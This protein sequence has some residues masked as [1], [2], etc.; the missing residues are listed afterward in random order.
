[1]ATRN[2]V[3]LAGKRRTT[4]YSKAFGRRSAPEEK[5]KDGR[6]CT[7]PLES[8]T[9][10]DFQDDDEINSP[11]VTLPKKNKL[12]GRKAGGRMQ[13]TSRFTECSRSRLF[14]TTLTTAISPITIRSDHAATTATDRSEI[15]EA[16]ISSEDSF[17]WIIQV[18]HEGRGHESIPKNVKALNIN[19]QKKEMVQTHI[20]FRPVQT[21]HSV[22]VVRQE[23]SS[24]SKMGP[25][26]SATKTQQVPGTRKRKRLID[27]LAAQADD[28]SG[29]EEQEQEPDWSQV[30]R[31][32]PEPQGLP[33][34]GTPAVAPSTPEPKIPKKFA[35]PGSAT[36]RTGPKITYSARRTI[37]AEG[38]SAGGL[39][40][41]DEDAW[42]KESLLPTGGSRFDMDEDED[43]PFT[44][45][46]VRSIHELRQAGANTR[47]ADEIED[48]LARV[49]RPT[50]KT[51][52]SRRNALVDLSQKLSDK[53]FVR[54]FRD[55]NGDRTLFEQVGKETD[56]IAGYALVAIL[57]MLLSTT[58]SAHIISQ[59]QNQG[60]S[61][62]LERL[63]A[64]QTDIQPISKDRSSNLSRHGQ[65]S[66]SKLKASL[67]ILPIWEPTTP[68]MLSP[69]RLALKALELVV[70]HSGAVGDE[71][72]SAKVTDQLF[73]LLSNASDPDSW[74]YP[75]TDESVDF[76]LALTLLES[77]SV[78]AMQTESK[79]RWTFKHL[80]IIADTLET[81]L[82][83]NTNR[84][85]EIGL[86][87]LK[88]TLNTAN[89]NHDAAN[90][91]IEK[92]T[93][94]T[95]ANALCDTFQ[96]ATKSVDDADVF[97]GHLESLLLMLG[98]MI[99][100]SEH[101]RNTG[102][103]LLS[104]LED[105]QAPLDRLIRLFLD[106]HAATSEADSVEKSQLNVA[107][108]YLSLLLGYMSLYEPVR[109]RF[110]SMHKAGN[111][112]PLLDSIRE[113]IAYHRM[114]D[115]AIA[116]TGEG[117]APLYSSFTTKLQGLVERLES[118]A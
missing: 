105:S 80:P 53:S 106:H 96:T 48:L 88:L 17:V 109:Q 59:L 55:H 89:N 115:D 83:L 21:P 32:T 13:N 38:A 15:Y 100:F 52:S 39:D 118:Y 67:L 62:L 8:S 23:K 108:G 10:W 82:R 49:G 43:E 107:F 73:T 70:K 85:G 36:K 69:R 75:R 14:N 64:N 57:T 58:A 90:A 50:G 46:A 20:P 71:L 25:T 81:T 113:F 74:K 117:Q 60:F 114:T 97:N 22:P 3:G 34:F 101:D 47:F 24:A 103:S 102:G 11:V 110:S 4:T 65:Q 76:H 56:I 93:V 95:L 78:Q 41:V 5:S 42:L 72:F 6:S 26:T 28:S 77:Y 31:R 12:Y 29:E 51:L 104:I 33:D 68:F 18:F 87:V 98:V 116:Q 9:V 61:S 45:G 94:R 112:V 84:L 63:L 40:S 44:S 54:K 111:M 2:S 16:Q 35:R 27:E 79:E 92:G 66:M 19:K 30:M 7:A 86:L 1:M 99:N 91:F 37:R